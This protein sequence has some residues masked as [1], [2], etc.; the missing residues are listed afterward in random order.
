MRSRTSLAAA[1]ALVTLALE[2][3][4]LAAAQS[5]GALFPEIQPRHTGYLRVSEIHEIYWEECG[6]PEG[7]PA[8][9]LHGGPGGSAGPR[10]RRFF[11][12]ARFRVLL[13]DQRGA[14]RSRPP[15]EWRENTTQLLVED[16]ET[17]RDHVGMDGRAILLGGSWGSTLAVAYAE[18]HPDKVA[19]LVLRG[20]FL[21]S[22]DEI[23]H[24]Y[25]GG[26][27]R[28]FPEAWER[29][30]AA[31]PH[32]E[33]FDYP[34]QLF[35]TITKGDAAARKKAIESWAFYEIRM[36]STTMT[37][38]ECE[39]IVRSGDMTPFSLLENWYMANGCFLDDDQLLREVGKIAA[40]PTYIANGRYDAICP[41]ITAVRLAS[42]LRDVK[43]EI[44]PDAGHTD[45]EPAIERALV[46]GVRWVAD[47][48]SEAEKA[49]EGE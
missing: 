15:A 20:V 47:R 16:I 2:A 29:L 48:V 31:L 13:F 10:M 7:I 8:I 1:L 43:L 37:D 33:R 26:A 30:R 25:H 39:R 22:K 34:H 28:F 11:D 32:P 5:S 44:V 21:A 49:E 36:V 19:G 12:P 42:K 6:N 3:A 17:L 9:V 14:G 41:P 45:Y 40:I 4:P 23:D 18:T 35:E 38:G 27:A 24:F 46:N